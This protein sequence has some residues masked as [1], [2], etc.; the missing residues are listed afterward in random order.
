MTQKSG[1]VKGILG[2]GFRIATN[3][4]ENTSE[5]DD[6]SATYAK[7]IAQDGPSLILVTS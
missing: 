7:Q 1:I 6:A 4:R 2:L 3:F 5:Y